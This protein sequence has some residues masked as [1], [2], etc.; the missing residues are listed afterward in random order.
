M[1]VAG[2]RT[3]ALDGCWAAF[4]GQGLGARPVLRK[5]CPCSAPH[6]ALRVPGQAPGATPA[7]PEP[8]VPASH[9]LRPRHPHAPGWS[10]LLFPSPSLT[11]L[12]PRASYGV[13]GQLSPA[14]VHTAPHFSVPPRSHSFLCPHACQGL[15]PSSVAICLSLSPDPELTAPYLGLPGLGDSREAQE[16]EADEPHVVHPELCQGRQH[17]TG[18]VGCGPLSCCCWAGGSREAVPCISSYL[19]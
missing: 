19:L 3:V 17:R 13:P 10:V 7:P 9:P 4:G 14:F 5:G 6:R 8:G 2:G 18:E 1:Q 15:C 12:V 16:G 11:L